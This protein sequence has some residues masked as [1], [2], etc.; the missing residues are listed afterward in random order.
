MIFMILNTYAL[1]IL[2][3]CFRATRRLFFEAGPVLRPIDHCLRGCE[4]RTQD[5][6]TSE[7]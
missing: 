1:V 5:F 3:E 2:H 7:T 4:S 6:K